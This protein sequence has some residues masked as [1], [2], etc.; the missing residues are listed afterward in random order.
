MKA[1]FKTA[2]CLLSQQSM[3]YIHQRRQACAVDGKD[4]RIKRCF[5][6]FSSAPNLFLLCQ[7]ISRCIQTISAVKIRLGTVSFQ[8]KGRTLRS[9][10]AMHGK[11]LFITAEDKQNDVLPIK[12]KRKTQTKTNKQGNK[13]RS[14]KRNGVSEIK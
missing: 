13:M 8:K 7:Q 5:L 9:T 3:K 11:T 2:P 4:K 1:N 14:W 6:F 10:Q 12:Q